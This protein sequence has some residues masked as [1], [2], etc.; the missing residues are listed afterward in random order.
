MKLIIGVLAAIALVLL[1]RGMRQEQADINPAAPVDAKKILAVLHAEGL[2]CDVVGSYTPLGKDRE[3]KWEGY[4][5]RCHDGG[6]YVYYQNP[7]KKKLGAMTC[8][9]EQAQ[10]YFCP[11]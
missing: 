2:P 3:G 1:Y 4:L 7:V 10:G 6:R 9:A 8:A 11:E 5:A